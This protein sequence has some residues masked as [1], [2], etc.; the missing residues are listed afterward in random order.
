MFTIQQSISQLKRRGKSIEL[1]AAAFGTNAFR[2]IRFLFLKKR[3]IGKKQGEKEFYCPTFDYICRNYR[4]ENMNIKPT[5]A[6]ALIAM[7][8]IPTLLEAQDR[9]KIWGLE[10]SAGQGTLTQKGGASKEVNNDES[11]IFDLSADYYVTTHVALNGGIYMEQQGLL[12]DFSNSI[13]LMKHWEAGIHVGAKWYPLKQKW[14]LQPYVAGNIYTNVLNLT[15]QKGEKD[16]KMENSFI[17]EGKLKYNIHHPFASLSPQI[18]LD[19]RLFSSLS[20]NVS[21]DY[22]WAL[23]GHSKSDLQ[24]TKGDR[25][26]SHFYQDNSGSRSVISLGLKYDFPARK[27]SSQTFNTLL[28]FLFDIFSPNRNY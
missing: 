18:G 19:V 14:I 5:P 20:L 24:M 4:L 25:I 6:L 10:L 21:Y 8:A 22:R 3:H 16:V 7:L 27:V 2:K 13:G 1:I 15:N 11:N 23:Y 9:D 12:S 26:G 17:G 28:T